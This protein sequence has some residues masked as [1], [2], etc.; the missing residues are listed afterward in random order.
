M[1]HVSQISSASFDVR[2]KAKQCHAHEVENA[3][4]V[5]PFDTTKEKRA[6]IF[7][8]DG[9]L[10]VAVTGEQCEA[11]SFHAVCYHSVAAFRRKQINAKRRRTI[12]MKKQGSKAA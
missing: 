11:N 4:Y 12:A 1:I 10:C 2:R 3:V 6:V 7:L 8:P 9:I 5:I